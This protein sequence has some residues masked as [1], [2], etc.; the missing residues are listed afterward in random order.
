MAGLSA[1]AQC[2]TMLEL[3]PAALPTIPLLKNS[4]S[5]FDGPPIGSVNEGAAKPLSI[6]EKW[7]KSA[8]FEDMPFSCEECEEA[9]VKLCAF[10]MDATSWV[11]TSALLCRTWRSIITAVTLKGLKLQEGIHINDILELVEEEGIPAGLLQAVIRQL[12][13]DK[14][15]PMDGCRYHCNPPHT[16]PNTNWIGG[17]GVT[18]SQ[19]KCVPWVGTVLLNSETHPH[20]GSATSSFMQQWKSLLPEAWRET[21]ALD[22]LNVSSRNAM[23]PQKR[24]EH[25][26]PGSVFQPITG[27]DFVV[28]K[29]GSVR[30]EKNYRACEHKWKTPRE[31]A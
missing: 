28:R 16:L 6:S 24:A 17:S 25:E 15:I 18:L 14:L 9:W 1:I 23:N 2:T 11:P 19:D 10:E 27:P 30:T 13:S 4:L 22:L 29:R 21:A 26:T 7:N 12:H 20:E 5:V 3:L 31:V 8:I